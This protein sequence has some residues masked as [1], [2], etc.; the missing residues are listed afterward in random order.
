MRSTPDLVPKREFKNDFFYS[1]CPEICEYNTEIY[2]L[3]TRF[4]VPS[5]TNYLK[6]LV[7]EKQ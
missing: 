6:N 3:K 1:H 2:L 4:L 7:P 5:K